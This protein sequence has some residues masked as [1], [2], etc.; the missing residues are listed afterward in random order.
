VLTEF[1]RNI[2]I[3]TDVS[4][5]VRGRVRGPMPVLTAAE[6]LE[7]LC[8]SY[9]LVSYFDGAKLHIDSAS[10]I[11]TEPL[12]LDGIRADDLIR[13]LRQLDI[14]D[15]RYPVKALPDAGIISVSGPPFYIALVRH[16]ADALAKAL[17]PK[18]VLEKEQDQRRVRVFRG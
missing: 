2:N 15:A 11:K 7:R 1:G 16:T 5:R 17:A 8:A 3:P 10:E 9:G 6:F 18:P 4:D 13:K 14:I 12:N